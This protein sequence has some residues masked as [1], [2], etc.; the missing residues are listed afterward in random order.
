MEEKIKGA[1]DAWADLEKDIDD[2]GATNS[3]AGNLDYSRSILTLDT[4]HG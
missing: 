3:Q 4:P 2:D 1:K